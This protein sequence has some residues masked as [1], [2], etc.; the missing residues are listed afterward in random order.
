[1]KKVEFDLT[2]ASVEAEK[3]LHEAA[4]QT[5]TAAGIAG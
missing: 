5:A 4:Q 1:M 2:P 3:E